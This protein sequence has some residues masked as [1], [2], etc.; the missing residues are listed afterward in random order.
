MSLTFVNEGDA[1][2]QWNF[3]RLIKFNFFLKLKNEQKNKRY[4]NDLN[5]Y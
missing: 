4:I 1:K 3:D 2:K 5:T